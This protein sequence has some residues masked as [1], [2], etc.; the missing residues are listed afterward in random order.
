M[1]EDFLAMV[2]L[3]KKAKVPEEQ[4]EKEDEEQLPPGWIVLNKRSGKG[5]PVNKSAS[6]SYTSNSN[7][8]V[9]SKRRADDD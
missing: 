5:R 6:C 1:K 8:S 7:V 2:P 9:V 4:V 3:F